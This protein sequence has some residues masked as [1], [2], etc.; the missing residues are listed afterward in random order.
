[1]EEGRGKG[2]CLGVLLRAEGLGQVR[3]FDERIW[4]RDGKRV[5]GMYGMACRRRIDGR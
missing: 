4:C 3:V 2:F 5:R 1:M